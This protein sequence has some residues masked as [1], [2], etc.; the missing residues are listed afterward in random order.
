MVLGAQPLRVEVRRLDTIMMIAGG[1]GAVGPA[2]DVE[3]QQ[4][5]IYPLSSLNKK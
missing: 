3:Q 2:P 1:S 5:G 4:P